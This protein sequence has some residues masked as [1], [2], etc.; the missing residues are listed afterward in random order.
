LTE[1]KRNKRRKWNKEWLQSRKKQIEKR[2]QKEERK[3][4]KPR[5]VGLKELLYNST[6]NEGWTMQSKLHGDEELHFAC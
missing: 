6:L 4:Y 2:R 5:K 3:G 1:E